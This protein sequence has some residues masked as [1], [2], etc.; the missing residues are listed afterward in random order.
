MG[1]GRQNLFALLTPEAR[2]VPVFAQRRHLLRC[3]THKKDTNIK[4]AGLVTR[5]KDRWVPP[6][7]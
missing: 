4:Q 3:K 6:K 5:S 2:P 1:T 7:V